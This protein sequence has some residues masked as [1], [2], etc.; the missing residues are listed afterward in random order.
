MDRRLVG[1]LVL[2]AVALAALVVP[3]AVGR[4][5][6]GAPVAAVIAGPPSVG[7]CV[8][9]ISPLPPTDQNTDV[10]AQVTYPSMEYGGCSGQ[11]IGEVM[12]VDLSPH[13]LRR[14]TV[15]SY[16]LDSATC[17]LSEVNYVGSIGPFDPATITTP[18][19]AW[20]ADVTVQ[21]V[22]VGPSAMQIQAGRSWT[23]CIGVTPDRRP[24][25]GRLSGAL[26]TG[27]LP[28]EFATCWRSLLSATE[29]Q[30][31]EQQVLCSAPHPVEVLAVTQITEATTTIAQVTKSC[32][33][34]ASR[35]LRTADPT[36]GGRVEIAAY[37][38]DGSSVA[39][40]TAAALFQGYLGCIASMKPPKKLNDTLIGISSRPLPIAR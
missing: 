17:E 12:S 22:S 2:T 1:V 33:G 28:P 35:T 9:A 24:Y 16:E 27:V 10:D 32:L 13:E 26:T 29:Q 15:A 11:A 7:D 3:G 39:P 40:L 31:A 5:V 30:M 21:S 18:G 36:L 23:A 6:N 14:A 38:L 34:M 8:R 19:I 20:Q 4:H 25:R 37:S